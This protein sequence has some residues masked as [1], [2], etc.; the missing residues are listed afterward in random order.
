MTTISIKSKEA[1]GLAACVALM[2]VT[3][4]KHLGIGFN[5]PDATLAIFFIAGIYLR[6]IAYPV[7][8]MAAATLIDYFAVRHGASGWCIT[9]AYAFLIPTY[10]T[11]WCGG[12]FFASLDIASVRQGLVFATCRGPP[13]VVL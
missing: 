12:K 3:R 4:G 13:R 7:L 5:L 9:P 11:M 2:I 10:L 1:Y 8:L 6:R